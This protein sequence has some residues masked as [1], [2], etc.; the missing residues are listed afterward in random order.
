MKERPNSETRLSRIRARLAQAR[1]ELDETLGR[2]DEQV[3]R[4]TR[5]MQRIRE[6]TQRAREALDETPDTRRPS[7]DASPAPRRPSEND[8][9]E[10]E[11]RP[12]RRRGGLMRRVRERIAR[13]R[14]ALDSE[15]TTAPSARS[16]AQAEYERAR[17]EQAERQR[18]RDATAQREGRATGFP[19]LEYEPETGP[20]DD[21]G[22][23]D[24]PPL[25]PDPS[26]D[27][28]WEPPN[29]MW[30]LP[31]TRHSDDRGF[32]VGATDLSGPTR[33][34]YVGR[35]SPNAPEAVRQVLIEDL[36]GLTRDGFAMAV[37]TPGDTPG[38]GDWE[39]IFATE[40]Q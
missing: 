31:V 9:P 16:R 6:R 30:G 14:A 27:P 36:T 39:V 13:S 26:R 12:T 40:T 10:G 8:A 29:T 33:S 35:Y 20:V 24:E 18:E 22:A 15:P 34:L 4:V 38:A 23:G 11:S 3:D 1:R 21:D 17:R 37:F 32:T 25:P 2:R 19:G 28:D 5:R 7:G